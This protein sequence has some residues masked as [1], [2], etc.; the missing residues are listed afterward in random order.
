MKKIDLVESV[1]E[2]HLPKDLLLRIVR[3]LVIGLSNQTP[4]RVF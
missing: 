1:F 2:N 3:G 4:E